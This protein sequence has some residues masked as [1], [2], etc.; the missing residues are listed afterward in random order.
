MG[1]T[2]K[3]PILEKEINQF[4]KSNTKIKEALDLFK[5]SEE[6][7]TKAMRSVDPQ[8]TTTNKATITIDTEQVNAG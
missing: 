4:L 7:Y 6:Q 3:S 5:I 2:I 1:K 8:P